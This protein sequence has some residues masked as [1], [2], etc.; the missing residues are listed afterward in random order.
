MVAGGLGGVAPVGFSGERRR[1]VVQAG[2][3]ICGGLSRRGLDDV[4]GLGMSWSRYLWRQRWAE[5]S[6][7]FG[8]PG[9]GRSAGHQLVAAGGLAGVPQVASRA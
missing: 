6:R 7:P 3:K 1:C 4:P 8:D 2:M 5:H 9:R